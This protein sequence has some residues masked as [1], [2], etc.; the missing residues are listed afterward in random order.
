[1]VLQK[2]LTRTGLGALTLLSLV[3]V[4]TT[5]ARA[6]SLDK[7]DASLKLV[8][9]NAAFYSSM[10][11]NKEQV[12][13][14]AKSKAWA[15][16]M[17]IPAVQQGLAMAQAEWANPQG[18]LAPLVQWYGQ[19]ENQ[20]LV[21]LLGEM[22]SQEMFVYGGEG[23]SPFLRLISEAFGGA[24][25]GPLFAQL[26]GGGAPVDQ[27]Q[28]GVRMALNTLAANLDKIKLPELVI[29]FKVANAK[30]ANSQ[31]DRLEN[32]LNGLSGFVPQLKDRVK[33]E[34]VG[35]IELLTIAL[36][37]SQVPWEQLPIKQFEEK[38]GQYDGLIKKLT[39]AKLAIG[40]G[41]REG[42]LLFSIGDSLDH[43]AK[44][45]EGKHLVDRAEFKPLAEF[46]DKRITSISY[47]SKALAT[48]AGTSKEDLDNLAE[49]IST[50]LP[51]GKLPEDKRKQ[52]KADLQDLANDLK[53]FMPTPG[54]SMAFTFL[55]PRGVEGY[56]YQEGER[57][58]LDSSK[59]LTILEN[60]GG[61]PILAV[62][63]RDKYKPENYQLIVKWVKKANGYVE[64]LVVP[65]LEP[66]QKENYDKVMKMAKPLL[67]RLDQATGKSLIPALADGQG[68]LVIDGKIT[69]KQWHG[70][71]PPT[72]KAL[73]MLEPALVMGVSDAELLKKAA[74][75]Y[76][77]IFNDFFVGLRDVVPD[78]DK[79]PDIKIPE[80]QAEKVKGGTLYSVP[81][82]AEFQ[83]DKQVVPTA[84][85][86]DK[87][88]AL[89]LSKSHAERL[90]TATPLK[91]DGGPL[92]DLK[93]NR[94]KA[95]Y[96]NCPAILDVALPWLEFGI[97][98]GGPN[99]A[100]GMN[101]DDIIKQVQMGFEVLKVF[102]VYTSSTYLQDGKLVTHSE[103]V[104]KDLD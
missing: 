83:L 23:W 15:K 71:M 63:G 49:T 55:S 24:R 40:L 14:V 66:Q 69:S 60:L 21:D 96:M 93:R 67:V 8:P 59:P 79:L 103:T 81:L 35:G 39:E 7:L 64:D 77:S 65:Q 78:K 89:T 52:I 22:S 95:I 99:V 32:L 18:K 26:S 53:A 70:A 86:T 58:D 46:A 41:M 73:P 9:E 42:Y 91:L 54:S 62:V 36:D 27:S 28:A 72:E 5:P 44:L 68:A 17:S 10:L 47:T 56:S 101:P 13:I 45:K 30:I 85:L 2:G 3:L 80:P 104:I 50:S 11:R 1:M 34:K 4:A 98:A 12:E 25:Y 74:A 102:R 31:I 92:A 90:I 97:H 48:V 75:E 82:P 20:E 84:G 100:G 61:A 38:E 6:Q 87:V 29:G 37:G 76:R 19:A 43:L 16:L 33:K 88:C 57:P 51:E 94:A